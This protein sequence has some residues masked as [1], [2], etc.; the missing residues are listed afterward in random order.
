[1]GTNRRSFL[2][3]SGLAGIGLMAGCGQENKAS[4]KTNLDHIRLEAAKKY[5]AT[6]NMSG[7]AAPKIPTVRVGFIGVAIGVLLQW[8]V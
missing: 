1:M 3:L 8:N 5:T 4:A 6:F 7:Y 2:K